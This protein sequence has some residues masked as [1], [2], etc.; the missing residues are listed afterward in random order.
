[1]EFLKQKIKNKHLCI[2]LEITSLELMRKSNG[3]EINLKKIKVSF[4]KENLLIEL[5]C[6][7]ALKSSFK[8]T[9]LVPLWINVRHEYLAIAGIALRHLIVFSTTYLCERAF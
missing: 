8:A 6:N 5:S 4:S 9:S 3:K 7:Q 1:M 2:V